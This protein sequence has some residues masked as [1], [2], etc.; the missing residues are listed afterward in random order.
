M[1][2][3]EGNHLTS[4]AIIGHDASVWAQSASFPQVIAIFYFVCCVCV[5]L[6]YVFAL[7]E[8]N[9]IGIWSY[10]R[11]FVLFCFDFICISSLFFVDFIWA[12][13]EF[14]WWWDL[15][16]IR[17]ECLFPSGYRHFRF[18]LLCVWF[19]VT[20]SLLLRE[21]RLESGLII[22]ILYFFVL[23]LFVSVLYFLLI[24]FERRWNSYDD[25]TSVLFV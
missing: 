9:S 24:W 14:V 18:R 23:I 4:A 17:A 15:C 8:R 1:C 13:M 20:L 25:E 6:C 5:I 22:G 2:E 3:I 11:H 16:S 19:Y 21:I 10:N 12:E 7:V